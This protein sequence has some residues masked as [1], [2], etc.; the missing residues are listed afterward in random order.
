MKNNAALNNTSPWFALDPVRLASV[1]CCLIVIVGCGNRDDPVELFHGGDYQE[2]FRIF[3]QQA[4][5]GDIQASNYLGM[6]YYLGAGVTRDFERAAKLFEVAALAEIPDSQRNLGVMYLRGL[7]VKKDYHQAYGWFFAAH[8]GGNAGA[9]E[10]L[11]LMGDNVTPNASGIAREHV[12]QQ[13]A[14][15]AASALDRVSPGAN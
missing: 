12:R 3:S 15:H 7:G 11:N 2:S 1:M 10:Y 4:T 8:A 14:A 6:H 13:I 9:K 5:T